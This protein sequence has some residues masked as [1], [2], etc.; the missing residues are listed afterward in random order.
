MR[1]R[2]ALAAA[3]LATAA[4][5]VAACSASTAPAPAAPAA[6]VKASAPSVPVTAAAARTAIR[7]YLALYSAGQ[8]DAAWQYLAPSA[9]KTAPEK[10][11]AAFHGQCPSQAAGLAYQVKDVTMAGKTAV[12]TYTIPVLAKA[13]GSATAAMAWTPGGW[14][15]EM[16]AAS[17]ALYSHGSLA[18]DLKAAK[19]AG[20]C[21]GS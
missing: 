9:R 3:V 11:Y 4:L 10:L 12:I 14:K 5:A 19:A 18:A 17:A 13:F 2:N 1:T 8:W 15:V 16:D 21:S 20:Y 7:Q 6:T